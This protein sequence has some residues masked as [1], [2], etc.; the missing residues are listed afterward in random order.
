MF[1]VMGFPLG[2]GFTISNMVS[3]CLILLRQPENDDLPVNNYSPVLGKMAC[4]SGRALWYRVFCD[5]APLV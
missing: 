1:R 3:G 2:W 4:G 5:A